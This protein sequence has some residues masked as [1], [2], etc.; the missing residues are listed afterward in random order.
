M[1]PSSALAA[2]VALLVVSS[3]AGAAKAPFEGTIQLRLRDA[4]PQGATY[5]VRDGR[6]RI[7]VPSI[8]GA[9]D[10]HFVVDLAGDLGSRPP[11]VALQRSG[12]MRAVVGQRCEEW[13]LVEGRDV[14]DACVV[15]GAG[16]Y[17]PRRLVGG[18]V[19]A[20]SRL[21]EI[22]HAFPISVTETRDGRS[23]FAMW[24]TDAKRE[25]VTDD[26]LTLAPV[27]SPVM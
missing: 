9:H 12:R 8:R 2:T 7:D 19:P 20:W 13:R 5:S 6:A 16:W 25:P 3:V 4:N 11:A 24:A 17:D 26:V 10:L 15:T 21:L 1:K 18:V 14:V 23:V 22:E 27:R